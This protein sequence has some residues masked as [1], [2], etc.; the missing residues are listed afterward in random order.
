MWPVFSLRE[1]AVQMFKYLIHKSKIHIKMVKYRLKARGS[2]GDY[3]K[4]K[5]M[6]QKHKLLLH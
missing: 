2:E 1:S 5:D 3:L 4:G 6:Y